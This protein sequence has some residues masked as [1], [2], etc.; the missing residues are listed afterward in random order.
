MSIQLVNKPNL[1]HYSDNELATAYQRG[2]DLAFGGI[3]SRYNQMIMNWIVKI[4]SL[5]RETAEDIVQESFIKASLAIKKGQY[6]GE[7][8]N[9]WIHMIAKNTA[10]NFLRSNKIH[11]VRLIEFDSIAINE[12]PVSIIEKKEKEIIISEVL[13]SLS[14]TEKDLITLRLKNKRFKEIEILTGKKITHANNII[15]KAIH[16]INRATLRA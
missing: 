10:L 2:N 1:S 11:F 15:K 4:T 13:N 3:F 8:F 5:D 16:K 6:R 9:S 7:G 14:A 12:S